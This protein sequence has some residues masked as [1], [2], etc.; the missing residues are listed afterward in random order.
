MYE[1]LHGEND[2]D[3][4]EEESAILREFEKVCKKDT[5]QLME[6][7][8]SNLISLIDLGK[9]ITHESRIDQIIKIV[10]KAQKI[11]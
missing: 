10:F 3:L 11:L 1:A 7:E 8:I 6:N 2:E 4:D 9:Q 5:F